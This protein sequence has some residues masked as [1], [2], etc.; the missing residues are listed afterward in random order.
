MPGVGTAV[1][2]VVKFLGS[3]TLAATVANVALTTALSVGVAKFTE[4]QL[5]QRK[6]GRQILI[7]S[8][9]AP[10]KIVYGTTAVSGLLAF[11]NTMRVS[12][13]TDNYDLHMAI[14]VAGHEVEDITDIF[15]ENDH[16]VDGVEV[17]WSNNE[18]TSGD[19]DPAG[20]R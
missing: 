9:V 17:D 12:G 10:K 2:G 8:A 19:Y 6:T 18:I 14:V 20:Q 3:G 4:Q 5:E 16:L 15:F 13:T 7:K 1:A 11:V